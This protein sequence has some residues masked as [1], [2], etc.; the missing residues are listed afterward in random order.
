MRLLVYLGVAF[1]GGGLG[2]AFRGFSAKGGDPSMDYQVGAF[3]A[4]I[5]A[6]SL[7]LH[8]YLKGKA[9]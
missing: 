2:L 7:F 5:G 6:G 4:L 1:V 8:H 9:P 3:F